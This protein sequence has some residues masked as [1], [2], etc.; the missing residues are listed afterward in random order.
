MDKIKKCIVC[1]HSKIADMRCTLHDFT[2]SNKEVH[3]CYCDNFEEVQ[4]SF[5]P[6]SDDEEFEVIIQQD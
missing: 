3:T 4:F 5:V 6:I 2:L 1:K